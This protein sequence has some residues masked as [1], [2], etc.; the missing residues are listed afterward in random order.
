MDLS[1]ML[2]RQQPDVVFTSTTT[3]T[4]GHASA[5]NATN[6]SAYGGHTDRSVGV[7]L[8]VLR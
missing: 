7:H 4:D 5:G 2:V 8:A 3:T 6:R 1:R